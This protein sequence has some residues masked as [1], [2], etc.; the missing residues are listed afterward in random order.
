MGNETVKQQK[1][2]N[3]LQ[4][5][6]TTRGEHYTLT[7]DHDALLAWVRDTDWKGKGKSVKG[8]FTITVKPGRGNETVKQQKIPVGI[9]EE[10]KRAASAVYNGIGSEYEALYE[11]K[12]VPTADWVEG[13]RDANRI[14]SEVR[15]RKA[16][17]SP[18]FVE[19]IEKNEYNPVYSK[20]QN[21]A[22][23]EIL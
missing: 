7:V 23:K 6:T 22:V 9:R 1:I 16:D 8:P 13:I 12:R 15:R 19:F 21:A 18:E 11:G 10:Y 5:G 4:S 14:L 3:V 17:Y 20:D 2:R